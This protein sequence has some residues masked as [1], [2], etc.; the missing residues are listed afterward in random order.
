VRGDHDLAAIVTLARNIRLARVDGIGV[1]TSPIAFLLTFRTYGTWLHGDPRGSFQRRAG[2]AWP[3]AL[4]PQPHLERAMRRLLAHPPV[5]L[6]AAQRRLV[7]EAIEDACRRNGWVVHALAVRTEHV[8]VVLT[9]KAGTAPERTMTAL[10]ARAT[11]RMVE[12]GALGQAVTCC[13]RPERGG[14][15]Q[16]CSG[17]RRAFVP[18]ARR[19]RHSS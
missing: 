2:Q 13:R 3:A 5:R 1:Q 6:D 8:H 7:T 11:R 18:A 16:A 19:G 14:A 10:K 17:G 12:R 15:R 4:S 9:T